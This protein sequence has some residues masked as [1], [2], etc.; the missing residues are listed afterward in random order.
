MF[1]FLFL[2]L[3]SPSSTTMKKYKKIE[4]K[5]LQTTNHQFLL[6]QFCQNNFAKTISDNLIN[7][8][9]IMF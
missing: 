5:T 9:Y 2:A 8:H 1:H 3:S 7:S 4:L 6:K